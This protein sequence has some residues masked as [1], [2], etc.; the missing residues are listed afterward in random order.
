[1]RPRMSILLPLSLISL[2][3]PAARAA[4]QKPLPSDLTEKV[5]VRL[6]ILDVVVVDR[7]GRPVPGLSKDD[8][9]LMVEGEATPVDTFDVECEAPAETKA[10]AAPAEEKGGGPAGTDLAG[11]QARAAEPRRIVFAL[12][13]AHVGARWRPA[14]LRAVKRMVSESEG[15]TDQFM[16]AALTGSLRVEQNFT[17]DRAEVLRALDRMGKDVTLWADE[18]NHRTDEQYLDGLI[19]LMQVLDAEPGSKAVVF[20]SNVDDLKG[21]IE[22]R[23]TNLAGLAGSARVSLHT[24]SARGLDTPDAG[25]G[26]GGGE[27]GHG[28][29]YCPG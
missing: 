3:P 15:P 28:G 6:V 25:D 20:L 9:R 11:V 26:G 27:G 7:Q 16:V 10:P 19:A 5:E 8:F 4:E 14:V 23:M 18:F 1:M 24:V 13:Y 29:G 2:L 21:E 17:A 12:D 22:G